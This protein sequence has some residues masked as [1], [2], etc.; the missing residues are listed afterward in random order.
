MNWRISMKVGT[1][2]FFGTLKM[3]LMSIFNLKF[4]FSDPSNPLVPIFNEIH[5][6]IMT[7]IRVIR[8]EGVKNRILFQQQFSCKYKHFSETVLRVSV[9]R[10]FGSGDK[11]KG[12]KHLCTRIFDFFNA[13]DDFC[14]N[15]MQS[16]KTVLRSL[17]LFFHD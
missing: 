8:S 9:L 4:V 5:Q 12:S 13:F 16:R 1:K 3:Y 14:F 15:E 7:C 6:F 17:V 10:I 11:L 2:G